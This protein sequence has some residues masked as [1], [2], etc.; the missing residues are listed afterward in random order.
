MNAQN[1]TIGVL[2]NLKTITT[3]TQG[4]AVDLSTLNNPGGRQLKAHL[5]VGLQ[6][7]TSPSLTCKIQESDTTTAADFAD[8]TG[9]TFT[10][11]TTTGTANEAIHFKATKRYVRL[12]ATTTSD[13]TSSTL[14]AVVIGEERIY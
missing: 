14:S 7:G 13:T 9:A 8:I 11:V 3:T 6:G 4:S 2:M 12:V 5:A 10:A 1:L